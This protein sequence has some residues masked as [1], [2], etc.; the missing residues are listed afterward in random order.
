MQTVPVFDDSQKEGVQSKC[1]VDFRAEHLPF[2]RVMSDFRKNILQTDLEGKNSARK[3]LGRKLSCTEIN[4]S[5]MAY[6]AEKKSYSAI[7]WG[8]KIKLRRF[9]EKV[10]TL[11]KSLIPRLK[12]QIGRPLSG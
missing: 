11:T 1:L 3:Y 9:G 8:K 4:I 12:S 6:N 10:L 2:E 7:C 5:L